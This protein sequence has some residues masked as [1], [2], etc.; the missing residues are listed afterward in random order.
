MADYAGVSG[1]TCPHCAGRRVD[2]ISGD[3]CLFCSG[4]GVV[5][6]VDPEDNEEEPTDG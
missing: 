5:D 2:A 1:A 3:W 4:K 6:R